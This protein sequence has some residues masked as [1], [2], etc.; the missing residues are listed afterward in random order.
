MNQ[1]ET[2]STSVLLK[3]K[4]KN[5]KAFLNASLQYGHKANQWNP[6]MAP[7][8]FREKQNQHI[9]DL[10]KTSKLLFHAGYFLQKI[11][12]KKELFYLLVQVEL[13]QNLLQQCQNYRTVI[14]LTIDG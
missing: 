7:Y 1:N 10:I 5:I 13:L 6:K 3:R 2:I 8:I 4:K 9:V 14:L 11:G 12:Q